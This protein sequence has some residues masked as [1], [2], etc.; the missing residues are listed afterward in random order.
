MVDLHVLDV[1]GWC[2]EIV[3][4]MLSCLLT[5]STF[6]YEFSGVVVGYWVC[7]FGCNV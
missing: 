6:G 5:L 7:W 4:A 1:V 3:V 2:L